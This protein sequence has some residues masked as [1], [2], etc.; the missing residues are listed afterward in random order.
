MA[1]TWRATRRW[2]PRRAAGSPGPA[3]AA[4]TS[5]ATSRA[6]CGGHTERSRG[7]AGQLGDIGRAH[8]VGHLG[9][10]DVVRLRPAAAQMTAPGSASRVP[11]A[12]PIAPGV[13]DP[14]HGARWQ[15]GATLPARR[16]R[17]PP[18]SRRTPPACALSTDAVCVRIR[19]GPTRPAASG[20]PGSGSARP[21]RTAL[22]LRERRPHARVGAQP[23]H[24]LV[25]HHRPHPLHLLV[26]ALARPARRARRGWRGAPAPRPT[27]RR[28]PRRSA[29]C[30]PAPA[31]ARPRW[32]GHQPQRPGQLAGGA[33]GVA[34]VL[35]VGLV[36][37]HDVGELEDALLDPLQLSRRC[38]RS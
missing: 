33:P 25:A 2:R 8:Q 27:P 16:S 14:D 24:Q 20:R 12:A 19:R 35:A 5:R 21:S 28:G 38:G 31:G 26:G 32:P 23:V 11:T 17:P 6:A 15:H 9:P 10:L 18:S 7:A 29:R 22:Q 34:L 36:H 4:A 13:Q 30:T 37:R 3:S 1:G